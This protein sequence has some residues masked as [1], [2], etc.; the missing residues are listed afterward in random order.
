MT[1]MTAKAETSS[2]ESAAV[3]EDLLAAKEKDGKRGTGNVQ[4][5]G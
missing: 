3:I 1:N 4:L 2:A 5:P